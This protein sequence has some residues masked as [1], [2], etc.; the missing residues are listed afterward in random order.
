MNAKLSNV[1]VNDKKISMLDLSRAYRYRKNQ[2]D[3]AIEEVL[4]SG[5]YIGGNV[6]EAFT[7]EMA[8]ANGSKFAIPCGNGTDALQLAFMALDLKRGDEVIVPAFTYAATAEAL[9]LLGVKPVMVDVNPA[10]FC[11]DPEEIIKHINHK[12]KAIVP[13]HLFGQV[14]QM[15]I[16]MEIAQQHKLYVVEDNAQSF[17]TSFRHRDGRSMMAGSIGHIGITS[18]FPTKNLACFGDGGML[19]TDDEQLA[20][21]IKMLANH[22]QTT[23]YRHELVGCNS[24]LDAIQ[25]AI[26]RVNLRHL[27]D[28][29]G[30]RQNIAARYDLAFR[31]LPHVI[32]PT[33]QSYSDHSFHQYTLV[34]LGNRRDNLKQ[35]L[36]ERGIET[37]VYYPLPLYKQPAY[38]RYFEAKPLPFTEELCHSVLSIP[39]DPLMGDEEVS[40]VIQ[41]IKTYL[42]A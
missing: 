19:F 25:A 1:H 29:I 23:K 15:D 7:Q 41:T 32:I 28:S 37:M 16:I 13:V 3:A 17:S 18:F 2:Y 33:R 35:Y 20:K 24:R 27:N 38:S 31:E 6:V 5:R 14:C 12:T 10:S 34:I 8:L 11:I 4:V 21:R 36:L 40:K 26:L 39:I 30:R 42:E 22:G 9:C